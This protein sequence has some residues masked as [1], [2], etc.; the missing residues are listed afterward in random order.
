MS[1]NNGKKKQ[2]GQEGGGKTQM[3]KGGRV[4]LVCLCAEEVKNCR[5]KQEMGSSWVIPKGSWSN[6]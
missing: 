4:V 2:R 5:K 3:A 1:E 6:I